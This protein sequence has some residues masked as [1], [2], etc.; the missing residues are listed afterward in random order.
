MEIYFSLPYGRIEG[1]HLKRNSFSECD[2]FK[3]LSKYDAPN[4]RWKTID[5]YSDFVF[6][7][8]LTV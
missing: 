7:F 6:A 3:N 4:I 2:F 5:P 1:F 8:R